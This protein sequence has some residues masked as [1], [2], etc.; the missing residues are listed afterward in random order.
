MKPDTPTLSLRSSLPPLP[1]IRVLVTLL[2]VMASVWAGY[3][4][5]DHYERAPWTRNGRV[6]ADVVQVAPDV[7]GIVKVVAVHDNQPVAAGTL[8]FSV[9]SARF[10]LA[11]HQA[12]ADAVVRRIAIKNQRLALAQAQRECSRLSKLSDGSA[13]DHREQLSLKVVNAQG[14]L[15]LAEA[16][17][18]Q[19]EIAV[20]RARLNLQRTEVRAPT[21][22]L[23]TN[24]D[25]HQ[26]AYASAAHP[27]L[28]LVDTESIY[29]EGYFEEHKLAR[30]QPGD[31]VRVTP[32]GAPALS[33]AVESIAAGIGD[34]DR[35]TSSNLLTS[36]NPTFSW[37]R[38]AQRVP[39][40]VRLDEIPSNR[41]L[42]SGQTATVEVL[43]PY[44]VQRTA[45]QSNEDPI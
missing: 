36:V 3:K 10:E 7:S 9:D 18:R 44:R 41:R 4:L 25:L 26:G 32:M 43:E 40:R 34:R 21:A 38:L 27:A 33:G 16:A 15:Q 11:L 19:A 24:L 8:L 1:V 14:A 6:R 22:G 28:A 39:V 13:P 17:L 45:H 23:V 42:V 37:V 30:I 31:R 20:D 12:E 29:V 5:W 35:S 2:T